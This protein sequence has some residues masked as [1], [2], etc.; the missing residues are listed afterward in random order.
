MYMYVCF[1]GTRTTIWITSTP[2]PLPRPLRCLGCTPML[3]LATSLGPPRTCGPSWLSCSL[4]ESAFIGNIASDIEVHTYVYEVC[5]MR[6]VCTCTYVVILVSHTHT[7]MYV[8]MYVHVH[9]IE[10]QLHTCTYICICTYRI[11]PFFF[12]RETIFVDFADFGT[13]LKINHE[14]LGVC[15]Q[16]TALNPW[17]RIFSKSAKFDSLKK[18]TYT[19][20]YMYMYVLFVHVLCSEHHKGLGNSVTHIWT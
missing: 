2:S 20:M 14:L 6:T 7:R 10:Y 1:S 4:Q 13:I 17:K 5:F 16:W 11:R 3:R 15:G 12:L 18:R 19:V 8:C 9:G